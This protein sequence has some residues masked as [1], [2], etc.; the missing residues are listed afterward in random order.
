MPV[1]CLKLVMNFIS[2][3]YAAVYAEALVMAVKSGLTPQSVQRVIGS[4]RLSNGFFDTFMS[5]AVGRDAEAHKFTIANAAKDTR[6]AG[7]MAAAARMANPLGAAIRNSFAQ[8]E[9]SGGG[10]RYVPML[11]D[12]IAALNGLDLAKA[13]ADA[14]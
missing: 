14:E 8:M 6:Y 3:G 13:V 1:N 4:S 5:Y 7:A 12:H 11:S 10:D 2:M 9:A